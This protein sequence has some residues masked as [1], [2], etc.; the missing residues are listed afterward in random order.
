[1][2]T[3]EKGGMA[4]VT[5]ANVY[6]LSFSRTGAFTSSTPSCFPTKAQPNM[7]VISICQLEKLI[8]PCGVMSKLICYPAWAIPRT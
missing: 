6:Q 4:T 5:I 8:R 3:E 2:L 7:A 1:M